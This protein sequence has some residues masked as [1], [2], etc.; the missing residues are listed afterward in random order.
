MFK[1]AG[2][3]IAEGALEKVQETQQTEWVKFE[4]FMNHS[5]ALEVKTNLLIEEYVVFLSNLK[6]PVCQTKSIKKKG[7]M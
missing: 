4:C 5:F 1:K 7:T 3:K 6:C 2:K